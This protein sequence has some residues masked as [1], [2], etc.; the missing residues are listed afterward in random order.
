MRKNI[1][2]L[3]LLVS[4]GFGQAAD[5]G[6]A[7]P[8]FEVATV[9]PNHAGFQVLDSGGGVMSAKGPGAKNGT[10]TAQN[11]SLKTLIAAAYSVREFQIAGPDWLA[12]ERFD[13]AA[14][15][16][17][18]F[19]DNQ[20]GPMLR[21]LLEERFHLQTHREIVE[22]NIY[23]LVVA[24]GGPKFHQLEAGEAF[25]PVFPPGSMT[26]LLNGT[27]ARW[28]EVLS[29]IVGRPVL[30]KTGL[31][32]SFMFMLAYDSGNGDGTNPDIFGAV[33]EELGLKL[34]SQTDPVEMLKV[35]RS[36]KVPS[37]N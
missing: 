4:S 25:K 7:A 24:K 29:G 21:A 1:A 17:K 6:T 36:D 20:F 22:S 32:G 34:D 14:K 18:G 23:A 27:M 5:Q 19:P 8:T 10:F 11:I 31:A 30:D 26:T 28:G 9:R 16:P 13:V 2:S 35:D 12:S 33:Q 37:G 3:V 15:L